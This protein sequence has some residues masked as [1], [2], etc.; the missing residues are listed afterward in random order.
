[1][2]GEGEE[3]E[4]VRYLITHFG[5][6]PTIATTAGGCT[7]IFVSVCTAG[8]T[9]APWEGAIAHLLFVPE[10]LFA[11]IREDELLPLVVILPDLACL[12]RDVSRGH[13]HRRDGFEEFPQPVITLESF[14]DL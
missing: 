5:Y 3:G 4:R 12:P 1:M 9:G 7:G 8:T 2:W 6:T 13:L 10:L 11:F 14:R